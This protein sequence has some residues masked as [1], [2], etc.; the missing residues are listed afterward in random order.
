MTDYFGPSIPLVL[1]SFAVLKDKSMYSKLLK[2]FILDKW[3]NITMHFTSL[4][5][6]LHRVGDPM[7][8]SVPCSTSRH[9]S[10]Y[11]TLILL[12]GHPYRHSFPRVYSFLWEI[13]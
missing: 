5:A 12:Q 11:R 13:L 1:P 3:K 9:Y 10:I 6:V 4:K 7:P 8:R 2:N